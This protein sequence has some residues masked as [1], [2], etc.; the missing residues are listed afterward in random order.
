M[1]KASL[2]KI[3]SRK[4]L[5]R[6][7]KKLM[8]NNLLLRHLGSPYVQVGSDTAQREQVLCEWYRSRLKEQIIPELL[9]KWERIV[10]VQTAAWGVKQMKTKWGTC[11]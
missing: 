10:G 2:L 5:I 7:P 11:C 6:S 1:I 3:C 9:E 4:F 8:L